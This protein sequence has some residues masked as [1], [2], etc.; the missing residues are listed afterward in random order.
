MRYCNTLQDCKPERQTEV[1]EFM[2]REEMEKEL[3]RVQQPRMR[4]SEPGFIPPSSEQS[5]GP[6]W[7][8]TTLSTGF[9]RREGQTHPPI[10][11]TQRWSSAPQTH[12]APV[13]LMACWFGPKATMSIWRACWKLV[14]CLSPQTIPAS[15][16]PGKS[17]GIAPRS[18]KLRSTDRWSGNHCPQSLRLP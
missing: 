4:G 16:V 9:S 11:K 7:H 2:E 8:P 10:P 14:G 6:L 13:T 12:L 17:Y 5:L 15:T 3:F 1:K 18:E